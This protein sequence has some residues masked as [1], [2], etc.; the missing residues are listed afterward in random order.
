MGNLKQVRSY[1][2][3]EEVRRLVTER[4]TRSLREETRCVVAHSLGSIVAYE[5]LCKLPP[6]QRHTLIT[7]GSPLGLPNLIFDRLKPAPIKGR[8]VWPAAVRTW[9][10]ITDPHDIVASVKQLQPLFGGQLQ[11]VTVSNE[12][13]AHDAVPYLTAEETGR[14]ILEALYGT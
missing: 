1:L 9:V 14:A 4:L 6:G 10:N 8:G 7:L 12:A 13:C 11:D 3:Q 5:T 2:I